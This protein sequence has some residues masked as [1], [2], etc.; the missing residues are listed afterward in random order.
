M[1]YNFPFVPGKRYPFSA[2]TIGNLGVD[3]GEIQVSEQIH[4]DRIYTSGY[5]GATRIDV[6]GFTVSGKISAFLARSDNAPDYTSNLPARF[7]IVRFKIWTGGFYAEGDG[8]ITAREVVSS[9]GKMAMLD[10]Q[11]ESDGLWETFPNA[12]ERYV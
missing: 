2:A 9:G 5:G 7:K 12:V 6:K 1:L 4:T 8:L 11:F 10:M 3:A